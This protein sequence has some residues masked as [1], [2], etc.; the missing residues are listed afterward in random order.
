MLSF[1]I[2]V[3]LLKKRWKSIK[4]YQKNKTKTT[5]KPTGKGRSSD[6]DDDENKNDTDDNEHD[7][8]LEFLND[9][10]SHRASIT[11]LFDDVYAF[12]PEAEAANS[13]L[14]DDLNYQM[15][16]GTLESE[17]TDTYS[18]STVATSS[19]TMLKPVASTSTHVPPSTSTSTS[20]V[21]LASK[22]SKKKPMMDDYLVAMTE[23]TN[24]LKSVVKSTSALS[25]A[26]SQQAQP[27]KTSM[28]KY[29]DAYLTDMTR[30]PTH[31]LFK[32]QREIQK[33][34]SD[35]L[36]KYLE[37]AEGEEGASGDGNLGK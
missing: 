15:D 27:E 21:P 18:N 11:N 25:A 10:P 2:S 16:I 7:S 6:E 37:M 4:D 28:E 29:F 1:L 35:I 24:M 26:V 12:D 31:L 33:S 14:L 34:V 19:A 36:F 9:S 13:T 30:L 23:R 17:L 8:Q 20:S 32:C 3:D 5:K 22:K